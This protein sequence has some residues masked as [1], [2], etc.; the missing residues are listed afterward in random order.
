M[1]LAEKNLDWVDHVVDISPRGMEHATEDYQSIHPDGLVPALVHD[2]TVIVESIDII[3]YLDEQFPEPPLRPD[4]ESGRREMYSWMTRAADV[5]HSLKTL[6]HEFLLKKNRM[7]P[8]QLGA[9]IEKHDNEEL[10]E[11][12]KT[13]CSEAGFSRAAIESELRIH[14]DCFVQLDRA[15]ETQDWLVENAFSLA[16]IAWAPNVRRLD[17]MSYPLERHPNLLAWYDRLKQ[18]PCYLKGV[19]D[20]EIEPALSHFRKYSDERASEGTGIAAFLNF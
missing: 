19:A 14:Y 4:S 11:F 12:M 2:G 7:T 18:R 5:Q 16:D 17:I 10:C 13:F 20:C 9:F 15:L 6:T 1:V 3:D 8:D